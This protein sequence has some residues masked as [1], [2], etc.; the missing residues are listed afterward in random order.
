VA[1]TRKTAAAR[2]TPTPRREVS[3]APQK[4]T[5]DTI[6]IAA[7]AVSIAAAGLLVD[8]RAEAAFEAPKRFAATLAIVVAALAVLALPC[9]TAP[10]QWRKGPAERRAAFYLFL[11]ALSG[12][13]IAALASP[14]RAVSLD[15]MRV[16]VLFGLL[17]PLGASRCLEGG[18][19]RLLLVVF[20]A[21]SAINGVASILQAL[22]VFEPFAVESIAGRVS[23]VGFVGNEGYLA[24]LMALAAVATL[25]I[26]LLAS[27]TSIRAAA[28]GAL[29]LFVLAL[30]LTRDV[31]GWIAL[32]VGALPFARAPLVNR[33]SRAWA[34][35]AL[36]ALIAAVMAMPA[37]RGR[38]QNLVRKAETGEW[39]QLLSYRL[40]PWAAAV[41]MVRE[42][43]LLGYGPGSFAAE[44]VPN[45]LRAEIFWGRR[46][47]NPHLNSF[48][49]QAHCEYLQALAEAGIPA[50]LAADAAFAMLLIGLVRSLGRVPEPIRAETH[51][52]AAILLAGSIAALGWSPLQ[53]PA[54]AV[55]LLLAAGRGWRVL[56][57]A[58]AG[59]P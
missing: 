40:V 13:L 36:L 53:E 23:S 48:Y 9:L 34:A 11:A 22:G 2:K 56:G 10:P 3:Q 52:V 46:L 59:E 16:L 49:A 58:A 32:L 4:Q 33:R 24:L 18:R 27:R 41:E 14:R 25:G 15:A 12:A 54:L 26:A 47:V 7:M 29:V 30:A 57:Q 50:G 42:R 17:V 19:S 6:A 21:V 37:L 20:L 51:V 44:F 45:R 38:A 39:D 35:A 43:P 55:P 28:W 5:A 8:P 1:N 31:T